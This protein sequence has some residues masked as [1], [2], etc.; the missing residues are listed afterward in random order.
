MK[1]V[2]WTFWP[3]NTHT[4]MKPSTQSRSQ[5][6]LT[7]SK[8]FMC[9]LLFF[10][11]GTFNMSST[12]L[13]HFPHSSVGKESTCNAGDP[14]LIPGLGRST[15]EGI[16]YPFQ[17][18]WGSA[19]KESACNAGDLDL[20]PGLGR[21]SWEGKCYPLQYSGLENSMDC[22]VHGVSES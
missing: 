16:S 20:I 5:R 19:G 11:V 15:G 4:L 8:I 12:L 10:M 3:T 21:P 14:S 1:K 9:S 17:Y 2:K 6:N 13:V 7:P 18:S 22:I